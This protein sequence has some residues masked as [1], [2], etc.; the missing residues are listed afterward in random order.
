MN[1]FFSSIGISA[2][3]VSLFAE[4]AFSAEQKYI[5]VWRNPERTMRRIFPDAK[6]YKTMTAA[7]SPGQL[8]RIEERAGIELL[9]GQREVF[10][11]YD[12]LGAEG[13]KIGTLVAASQKGTYGAIEFVFGLNLSGTITGIYVQ[14]ARERDRSFKSKAYLSRFVG[15]GSRDLEALDALLGKEESVGKSAIVH[16]IKKEIVALDELVR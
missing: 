2:V 7:I 3:L 12:M 8:E 6:D 4:P 10:Q 15:M 5:C 11:Y 1:L 9:P 14:R 16:G 13:N